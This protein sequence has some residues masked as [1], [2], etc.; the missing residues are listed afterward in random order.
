M[1]KA[2]AAIVTAIPEAV[3]IMPL[4]IAKISLQL[5]TTNK[6]KN[7]MF[8]SMASVAQTKGLKGN[9]SNR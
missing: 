2:L 5:D 9:L 1:T 8:A 6:F 7:N 3:S 4:E